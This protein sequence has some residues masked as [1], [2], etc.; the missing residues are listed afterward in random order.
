MGV[1]SSEEAKFSGSFA[2]LYEG[3]LQYNNFFNLESL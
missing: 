2:G 1:S 3:M